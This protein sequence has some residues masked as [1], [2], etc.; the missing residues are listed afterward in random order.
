MKKKAKKKI[1]S[2]KMKH[3]KMLIICSFVAAL[4]S[5]VSSL[6]VTKALFAISSKS[7]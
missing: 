6:V 2:R 3:I 4:F 1:S 7:K 5:A